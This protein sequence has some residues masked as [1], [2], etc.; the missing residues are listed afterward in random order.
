MTGIRSPD[1]G[2][3]L[4]AAELALGLLDGDERAAA[5]RR[6]LADPAFAREVAGWR[7]RFSGFDAE[8]PEQAAPAGVFPRIERT[9]D[10]APVVGVGA[11]GASRFWPA[12]AGLT[13]IA[14]AALLVVLVTRPP[15]P[16]PAPVA[17]PVPVPVVVV[18]RVPAPTPSP[19]P[20]PVAP[21]P[22]AAP[23][24]MLVASIAPTA[25]G[26][27]V[28]AVYDPAS[29]G[30]R[31]SG[32]AFADAGHSPQLWVIGG[33]GV[34]HSLGLLLPAGATALTIDPQARARLASGATLAVSVEPLGGSPKDQP[35]GPVV[36][37][38]ALSQ[39]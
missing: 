33:D 18:T 26:T 27:P 31:L 22:A 25:K 9:L 1:D 36:A 15:A 11:A 35:S 10:G 12:L 7:V 29:G 20:S 23:A 8:W 37:T 21:A 24:V 32:Q 14:A 2:P 4:A 13:S 17:T 16:S 6:V 3:E 5:L 28:T 30:L 34:P 19:T 39:V 38:G